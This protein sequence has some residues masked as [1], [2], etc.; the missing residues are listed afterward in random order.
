VPVPDDKKKTVM[1][2]AR[3]P[4]S[5]YVAAT[6]AARKDQEQQLNV[7]QLVKAQ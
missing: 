3:M 6:E 1:E 4:L 5:D 7:L 2:M